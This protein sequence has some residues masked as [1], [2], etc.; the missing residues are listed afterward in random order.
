MQV[1]AV[2]RF[3]SSYQLMRRQFRFLTR[4]NSWKKTYNLVR[5]AHA[6][7][8]R[9]VRLTS[10]PPIVKFDTNT[11]CNL[12][13][14][15]CHPEGNRF[16]GVTDWGQFETIMERL[17]LDFVF[18]VAL[19][20]NGEPLLQPRFYDMIEYLSE[21][22]VNTSIS[23]NFHKFDEADAV[24]MVRSGLSHIMISVDGATQAS[25]EKYRVGGDLKRVLQNIQVLMDTKARLKSATPLVEVETICFDHNMEEI[26]EISEIAR[27]LK[28]DKFTTKPDCGYL[29]NRENRERQK[30]VSLERGAKGRRKR[31]YWLYWTMNIEFDGR[32]RSCCVYNDTFGNLLKESFDEIWNNERFLYARSL[33][34]RDRSKGGPSPPDISCNECLLY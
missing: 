14:P 5:T 19:F 34:S 8:A 4:Q 9:K 23:T 10:Y 18:K 21:R 33:F 29:Y 12:R 22:K 3:N 31:C 20:I 16:G 2:T 11:F 17:P 27:R 13:C 32:V 25:Y 30:K 26:G 15:L 7:A 24:R 6:F 28:V 1:S